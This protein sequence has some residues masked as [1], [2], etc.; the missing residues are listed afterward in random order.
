MARRGQCH[1]HRKMAVHLEPVRPFDEPPGPSLTATPIGRSGPGLSTPGSLSSNPVAGRSQTGSLTAATSN[2]GKGESVRSSAARASMPEGNP[3]FGNRLSR[4]LQ[5]IPR[6]DSQ[7]LKAKS[8]RLAFHSRQRANRFNTRVTLPKSIGSCYCWLL[9]CG[10]FISGLLLGVSIWMMIAGTPTYPVLSFPLDACCKSSSGGTLCT[11]GYE[12]ASAGT[13]PGFWNSTNPDMSGATPQSF[14]IDKERLAA[15]TYVVMLD[16]P[17]GVSGSVRLRVTSGGTTLIASKSMPIG[18]VDE[19]AKD[20]VY[21][22]GYETAWEEDVNR[23]GSWPPALLRT[24][25]QY[26]SSDLDDNADDFELDGDLGVAKGFDVTVEHMLLED[27]EGSTGVLATGRPLRPIF[28]SLK[29]NLTGMFIG[30]LVLCIIFSSVFMGV[31]FMALIAF[32]EWAGSS[33]SRRSVL[34]KR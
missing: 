29:A 14:F 11:G 31:G 22:Q 32:L 3:S 23:C 20:I 13:C 33:S 19:F 30:G 27:P 34:P 21:E 15:A 26:D 28:I 1:G 24:Y 17:S 12:V 4:S 18:D 7:K 9:G 16:V 25:N 2:N 6:L 5:S 10:T 8:Q